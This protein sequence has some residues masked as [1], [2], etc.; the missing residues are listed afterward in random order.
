MGE[1]FQDYLQKVS[2]KILDYADSYGFFD[3]V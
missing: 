2:L 3:L 1:N